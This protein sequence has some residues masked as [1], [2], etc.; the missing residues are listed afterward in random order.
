MKVQSWGAL[1]RFEHQVT[2]LF[3]RDQVAGHLPT[4]GLAHGLGRSYGDVALNPGGHL[5]LCAGLDRF[6]D[7]DPLLGRVRCEAGVSL[8]SLQRL[9]VPRGWMLPVT[10]G[11]RWVSVGGAIANDV[12]GKNHHARGSWGHHVL[13]L[14]LVRSSGEILDLSPDLQPDLFFATLGGLGL[15]GV[16]TEVELQLMPV[17]GPWLDSETIA[18]HGLDEFFTLSTLSEATWEYSV[19]WIDCLSGQKVRG[20]FMRA[21]PCAEDFDEE[22]PQSSQTALQ[23]PLT[24]PFSLVNAWSLRAFNELY[25]RK[26]ANDGEARVHYQPFFYPLDHVGHW[27]RIYGRRGFYQYQSVI[28][29]ANAEA[30]TAAMLTEI[31][32]SGQGSFLAV[33]K[34]FG[35]MPSLGLLSFP[36]P[37]VTLALDFPQRGAATLRLF[38]RLDAIVAGAGGRL[39]MGKDARMP[40]TLFQQGYPQWSLF[41]SLRDPGISSAMSRRLMGS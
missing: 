2:A 29:T 14:R 26:H 23:V 19:A 9:F 36:M 12:H 41:Q 4:P 11:T 22:G 21:K 34:M 5:W 38:E 39:Y 6:I 18:F 40:A 13:S 31:Q 35:R 10:P 17:A 28:P 27:N 32:R 16:I 33:L 3:D 1:G 20:L 15:T 24:P 8:D 37:G 25:F 7:F 30:A